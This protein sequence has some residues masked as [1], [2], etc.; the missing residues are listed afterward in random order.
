MRVLN[1][2]ED[3]KKQCLDKR[4]KVA[5]KSSFRFLNAH[6][7]MR[8]G[9]THVVLS[10]T[11]AGKSTLVRSIISDAVRQNPCINILVWLSEETIDDFRTE[12]SMIPEQG[13]EFGRVLVESEQDLQ[14]EG[15]N[16]KQMK[17]KFQVLINEVMPEIVVLDNI[18]TSIFYAGKKPDEQFKVAKNLKGMADKNKF[19]LMLVAHTAAKVNEN[20]SGLISADDIRG[21]KQISNLAEFFYILQVLREGES[22]SSILRTVKHRGQNP[23]CTMHELRWNEV[24]KCFAGDVTLNFEN[25]SEKYKTRNKL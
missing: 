6:N 21:N 9:K 7:G 15:L 10:T 23:K 12:F 2:T 8:I 17:Q 11:G 14:A 20:Y 5:L 19:A 25:F 1:L 3:E 16:E 13:N 22:W 18:T 24:F 4:N